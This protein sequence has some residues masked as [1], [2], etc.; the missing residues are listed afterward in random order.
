MDGGQDESFSEK[1]A[2]SMKE[3]TIESVVVGIEAP[4]LIET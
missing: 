3:S 1:L 2:K 4:K